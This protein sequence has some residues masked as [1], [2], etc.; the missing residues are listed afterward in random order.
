MNLTFIQAM[1]EALAVGDSFGKSTEF[2]SRAA[3]QAQ[4]SIIQRHLLPGESPAHKDMCFAQVTD[5]TEQNFFLL[6][7][8]ALQGGI[9]PEIT[10]R[11]ILRWFEE[12]PC[13]QKYI[14]PSTNAALKKIKDGLPLTETGVAGFSCGGVMRIPAVYLC[15][16]TLEQLHKN[17]LSA[18]LPTHNTMAAMEAAMGYAYALWAAGENKTIAQITDFT[19]QGCR[20]GRALYPDSMDS[21]CFPA[22]DWRIRHLVQNFSSFSNQNDLLDFLFYVYG[23]TISS[24]DVFVAAY[25]LFLWAKEDVFTAIQMAAMLGGDTDTIGCLAAVLCCCYAQGHNIPPHI[26]QEVEQNNPYNFAKI[27]GYAMH[28]RDMHKEAMK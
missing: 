18:L 3:I 25:A 27:A 20:Y 28:C 7:D 13:P 16:N 26:V 11:S 23:T 5:D 1:L 6:E 24:C 2:V 9:T 8:Y 19:T 4:F 22:C 17:V 12:T 15:S 21:A 14:G 10:A